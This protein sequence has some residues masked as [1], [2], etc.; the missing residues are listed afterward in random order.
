VRNGRH[1]SDVTHTIT[2]YF[3]LGDLNTAAVAND[4]FV[5]NTFVFTAMALIIFN[6]TKNTLAKQTI[7]LGFVGTVIDGFGL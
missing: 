7:T 3:F 4:A 1:Q 6:R 5:P 2:K